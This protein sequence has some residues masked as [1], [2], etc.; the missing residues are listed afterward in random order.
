[1]TAS[2]T[3]V[4]R[5]DYYTFNVNSNYYTEGGDAPGTWRGAGAQ[6]LNLVNSVDA[7]VFERLLRAQ[8][9]QRSHPLLQPP[10]K[11]DIPTKV[12]HCPG[13]DITF[14]APKTVSAL[15]AVSD[16]PLQME[17]ERAFRDSIQ[18]VVG[19]AEQE[20]LLTRRGKGGHRREHAKLV[21]ASFLHT[22]SRNGDPQLHEHNVFTNVCLAADGK[23]LTLDSR[24]LHHWVRTLGPMFRAN[25]ATLLRNRLGLEIV[26]AVDARG[27]RQGWFEIAGIP[28]DLVELWSSRRAD[29]VEALE[30]RGEILGAATAKARESA[31][32][33]TRR[34]KPVSVSREELHT[35][36]RQEA[37]AHHFTPE[38]AAALC[39]RVPVA[40]QDESMYRQALKESLTALT[41]SEATFTERRLI[42]EVAE[43][44]QTGQFSG[45]EIAEKVKADLD[46]SREIVPLRHKGADR[47][48]TTREMWEIEQSL[49]K[50]VESLR[51]RPGACVKSRVVH[52]VLRS[53]KHLDT[54]QRAAVN[55]ILTGT[56][57][58][59]TLTGVAG[60]GKST[61]LA[62]IR[63]GFEAAGQTVI[64]GAISGVATEEVA[65]K[66]GMPSR[67]IGSYLYHLEKPT[68]ERTKDKAKH[69][70]KQVLRALQGRS[71]FGQQKIAL[72]AK[73]VLILDEAGMID[74]RTIARL[75]KHVK[76]AGATLLLV[77]DSK[78]LQ[79]V[80][81]GGP[82][83]RI[84]N[85]GR[86]SH[87][88]TNRRQHD[89]A[90]REAVQA[91]REGDA[92]TALQSYAARGRVTVGE[93]KRDTIA[94]LVTSWTENGGARQPKEH[95]AFTQTR[96]EAHEVNRRCQAA[97]L[98]AARTPH[99]VYTTNGDERFYRGD[100][101]LFHKTDRRR[102]IVN[103]YF[104]TVVSVD[105]I[106]RQLKVRLD[107]EPTE[108]DARR[109]PGGIVTVS[110]KDFGPD[111][112][113][114]GY[115]STTHKGQGRTVSH[116]Y[117]LAGSR[118]TDRELF[119]VQATRARQT[120]RIFVDRAHAGDEFQDLI[121]A[122]EKSR[123]KNL[124]HDEVPRKGPTLAIERD[125]Y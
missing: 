80:E 117:L 79:A 5:G 37:A 99:V 45:N 14:S 61:A 51:N 30:G 83:Q 121:A 92:K 16:R 108:A 39:H 32:L 112:L 27:K 69:V 116:A 31:A 3:T 62:A 100:R 102:G 64:G 50:D 75:V 96:A 24:T 63:E 44:L 103:G 68:T 55:E 118:M 34:E 15:W 29:L 81:A 114:L 13:F 58:I 4:V 86:N 105:P 73:T 109:W 107:R 2:I 106:R 124:A 104:G 89:A 25:F 35:R 94:K 71:T 87:L 125:R 59:K 111:G 20:L 101:V 97:R 42:Q 19:F 56:G 38:M 11:G 72:T 40:Q 88:S 113:S 90:D 22:T 8:H 52:R 98:A 115:A 67:T 1:M 123:A 46:Q 77:G 57:A 6:A 9:P 65:E 48:F 26:D 10:Q 53:H 28:R 21:V 54:E 12:E 93:N 18:S 41:K 119:Y 33:E 82:F 84:I 76:E 110:L 43:R 122:A 74:T 36:W 78:Q 70:A 47:Q 7:E 23:W 91:I 60:A 95:V 49:L 85:D 66:S 120:T 17:I